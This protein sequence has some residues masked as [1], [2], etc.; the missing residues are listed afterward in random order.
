[1]SHPAL[2]DDFE[3]SPGERAKDMSDRAE[4]VLAGHHSGVLDPGSRA[5]ALALLAIEARLESIER[6]LTGRKY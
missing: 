2:G 6:R 4:N 3:P 1:V 5:V